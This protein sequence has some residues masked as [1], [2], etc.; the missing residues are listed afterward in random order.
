MALFFQDSMSVQ[1]CSSILL[2]MSIDD[3]GVTNY[4]FT[5]MLNAYIYLLMCE[6]EGIHK[7]ATVCIYVVLMIWYAKAYF[8]D[9]LSFHSA[10]RTWCC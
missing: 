7:E 6:W 3:I 10:L 4:R 5:F 2:Y 9:C 1:L 8:W